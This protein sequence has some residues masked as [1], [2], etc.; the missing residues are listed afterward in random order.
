M[1]ERERKIGENEAL[2]RTVNERIEGL[3]Q[4]F[5]TLTNTMTVV[6]ECGDGACAE[7]IEIDIA[8]YERIR[9]DPTFFIIVPG[10]EIVDVEDVV[11]ERETFHVVQKHAGDPADFAREQDER[12]EEP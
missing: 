6:C 9:A 10:H 7:Q 8:D 11:E 12:T 5:G 2:Y 3:N 1:N 4:V